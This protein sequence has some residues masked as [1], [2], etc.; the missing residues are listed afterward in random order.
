MGVCFHLSWNSLRT[1]IVGSYANSILNNLRTCQTVFQSESTLLY[2]K[3]QYRRRVQESQHSCQHL[4]VSVFWFYF[5]H[6]GRYEAMS[7]GGFD[8]CFLNDKQCWG[9]LHWLIGRLYTFSV[10]M[11][12]S[13]YVQFSVGW[14]SY[15]WVANVSSHFR[16]CYFAFL[17]ESFEA[18]KF[19]ILARSNYPVYFWLLICWM[20]YV[21]NH[22]LIQSHEELFLHFLLKVT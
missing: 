10:V 19:L 7:H 3:E 14:S 5:S 9:T 15:Y 17:V 8:L 16:V 11:S 1:R 13:I 12:T 22:F 20:S 6:F 2:S 18:H 21:R 4:L